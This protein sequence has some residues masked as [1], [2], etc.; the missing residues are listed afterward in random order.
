MIGEGRLDRVR[1]EIQGQDHWKHQY[2][3]NEKKERTKKRQKQ[4]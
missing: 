1:R 2:L 3:W 4:W